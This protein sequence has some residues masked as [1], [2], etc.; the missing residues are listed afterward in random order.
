MSST[1]AF[2]PPSS[3]V[4]GAGSSGSSLLLD[5]NHHSLFA[6]SNLS[7]ISLLVNVSGG[8]RSGPL[9]PADQQPHHVFRTPK[10]R[11]EATPEAVL[12]RRRGEVIGGGSTPASASFTSGSPGS[13]TYSENT[14]C[15]PVEY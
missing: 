7:S 3:A 14:P 15:H 12:S 1:L 6:A 11:D 10:R 2:P 4:G 5:D 8:S 9:T 13:G